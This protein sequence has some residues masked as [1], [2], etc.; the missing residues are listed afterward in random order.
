MPSS[1]EIDQI[2]TGLEPIYIE[3]HKNPE[4]SFQEA[5][6]STLLA[7]ELRKLGFQVT[8]RVGRY[9]VVGILKNGSGPTVM[10]RTDMDAL[11]VLEQTGLPYPSSAKTKDFSGNEVPVMHACGHDLHMST[12]LGTATWLSGHKD[13]WSGTLMM[14]GQPAEEIG[15]GANAMLE[16]GL[17]KRFPK[18]D[19]AIALHDDARSPAGT[20]RYRSG[21]AM[22][23]SDNVDL[24]IYGKGG[25]GATPQLTI[26]PVVIAARTILALQTIVSRE[27]DPT[28]PWV[29]TVGSIHG[30]TK[31]NI[32]PDEVKL[33]LTVRSF[34]DESRE[35]LLS[36]IE[37][38]AKAEAEAGRAERSPTM[39]VQRAGRATYNDPEL[40][41]R[42]ARVFKKTFGEHNVVEFP[43][44]TVAEDFSEYG[45]AGVPASIFFVGAVNPAKFE[46]AKKTGATLPSLH[47]SLFA[48][49]LKPTLRTAIQAEISAALELLRKAQ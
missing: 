44:Q 1:A 24:T 39:R 29:I 33:Q 22:A 16:D 30:G 12:W 14:I 36:A 6:T 48:P 34:S 41:A 10:I 19:Y 4:I 23:N 8:E 20:V 27:M 28:D 46:E 49:D 32:I 3:L 7:G 35:K 42:L 9:G 31:H 38:V 47:S 21:W 15:Q 40:T 2:A 17:F 45:R 26:D 43:L 25:H 13:A 18:P 37:R 5:K 11:P